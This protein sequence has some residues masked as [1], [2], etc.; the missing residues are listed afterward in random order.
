MLAAQQ[1]DITP[2]SV[3]SVLRDH[4]EGAGPD[5]RP[6]RGLTGPTVCMHAAFGPIRFSQTS[7]SMVCHLHPRHTT[8]F[9]TGTAAPCT[10][11]FKPVW[12]DAALPDTGSVPE[13]T[14][15]PAM[16]WWRHER[17][18]RATL[19]DYP[20]RIGR[21]QAERDSLEARFIAGA[22]ERAGQAPAERGAFAAGCFDQAGEAEARWLEQV[23][24]AEIASGPNWLYTFSW[25]RVNRQ[26]G[27]PVG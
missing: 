18:H 8:H 23:S 26:A 24:G 15:D 17:L 20:T 13:A 25:N 7:G 11:L 4:G 6:D 21:Y 9:V 22:L 5:W 14:Y 3:I 1:R 12:L 27:I 10:S 2:G 16:L 19:R